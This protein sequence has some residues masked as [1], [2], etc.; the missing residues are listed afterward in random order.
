MT[1]WAN[2][3]LFLPLHDAANARVAAV[4]AEG[5]SPHPGRILEPRPLREVKARIY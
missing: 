2:S 3:Q 1:R 4:G 5:K